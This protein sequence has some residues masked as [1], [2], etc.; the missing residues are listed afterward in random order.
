MK[1][2]IL[3]KLNVLYTNSD[4]LTNKLNELHLLAV[5]HHLDIL[6]VTE[7]KPKHSFE[8]ITPQHIQLEG[9]EI[10]S[11]FEDNESKRG[12]TIYLSHRISDRVTELKVNTVFMNV[13]GYI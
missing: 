13:Y 8:P 11:N 4:I 7:V 3:N 6:M 5:E 10:Y 12:I 2:R 1:N 9:F